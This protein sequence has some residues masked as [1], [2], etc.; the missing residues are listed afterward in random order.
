MKSK[1]ALKLLGVSRVTLSTYV[2]NGKIKVTKLSNG[3]YDYDDKSI[4]DFL[5]QNKKI[6]VIY[7]RVSTY[8]QKDD[9]IYD[10]I[11]SE[12][13]DFTI[14]IGQYITDIYKYDEFVDEIKEVLRKSKVSIITNSID[15]D[16]KTVMWKLKVRK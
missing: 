1:E 3:Y 11:F 16:S 5:G 8:K 2:K 9:L 6:N 15:V 7:T 13:S 12:S 14:D 10:L 4:F